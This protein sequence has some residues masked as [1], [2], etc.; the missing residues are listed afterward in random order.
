MVP[1]HSTPRKLWPLL[2]VGIGGGEKLGRGTG[3]FLP[4]PP[5][6]PLGQESKWVNRE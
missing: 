1:K 5:P 2:G 3:F 6:K 4:H